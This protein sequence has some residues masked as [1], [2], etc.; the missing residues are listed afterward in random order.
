MFK[1]TTAVLIVFVTDQALPPGTQFYGDYPLSVGI[2]DMWDSSTGLLE[3]FHNYRLPAALLIRRDG[4]IVWSYGQAAIAEI[5]EALAK[6]CGVH[7]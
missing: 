7:K 3:A 2:I 1:V 4:E 6:Y 5:K